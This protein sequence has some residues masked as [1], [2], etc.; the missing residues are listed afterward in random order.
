MK[1][2]CMK[3][4]VIAAD[5]PEIWK[6]QLQIEDG[7]R[8]GSIETN[9]DQSEASYREFTGRRSRARPIAGHNMSRVLVVD[10]QDDV[11]SATAMVLRIKGFEVI[12]VECGAAGS[13][14]FEDLEFDLAVIDIFLQG[15]MGGIEIIRLLRER[16]PSLPI[17][18]TSGVTALDFLAQYPDSPT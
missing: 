7:L 9:L 17:I 1:P 12:A 8:S 2:K 6:W 16:E 18:A 5:A 15:G 3:C 11:R 14:E 13:K 10:D 4:M